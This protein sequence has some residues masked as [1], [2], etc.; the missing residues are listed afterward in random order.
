MG[1]LEEKIAGIKA[2]EDIIEER[3]TGLDLPRG[4]R[5]ARNILQ[6]QTR[7]SGDGAELPFLEFNRV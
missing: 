3:G 1:L 7:N 2:R 6:D 5:G 4:F